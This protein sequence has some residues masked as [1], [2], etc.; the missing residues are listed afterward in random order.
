MLARLAVETGGALP[1]IGVGGIASAD[2]A[3]AKIKAGA[4]AM[5]LYTALIYQGLSLAGDIA[6]G[7]DQLLD[8]DGLA[9]VAEAVG[10]EKEKYL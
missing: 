1:L 3:Y 7:L 8:R 10:V 2:Q 4:S 9:N 6:R 5:Q